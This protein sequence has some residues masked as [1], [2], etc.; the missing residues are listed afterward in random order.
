MSLTSIRS[1]AWGHFYTRI[2]VEAGTGTAGSES[3]KRIR[4]AQRAEA[5]AVLEIFAEEHIALRLNGRGDNDRVVPGDAALR[6]QTQSFGIESRGRMDPQQGAK[7]RTKILL[8]I[9]RP[10]RLGEPPEGHLEE[11]LDDLKADDSF[12]RCERFADQFC[13]L[14]GFG[15]SALVKRVDEY[16]CVEKEPIAH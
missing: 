14:L 16:V 9:R 7:N 1:W 5:L 6:L 4:D 12:L 10:H 15:G 8:R 13:G 2:P 11:F 3:E